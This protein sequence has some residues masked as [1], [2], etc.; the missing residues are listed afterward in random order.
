MYFAGPFKGAPLSLVAITPALAGPYDYGT[1][2]VRV[3]LH[4]DPL[5]AQVKAISDTV[6]AIIGGVPIRM[7]S[8]QVN[9]DRPNFTINPTSCAAMSVNSQG[10]GD[11]GTIADF[12][13]YFHA[14]NCRS[15]PF[16]PTMAIRQL[17]RRK[18]T[19]RTGNPRLQF[20]LRTRPGDANVKAITVTLSRAYA[21]D[22]THL[23]NICSEKELAA[24]ECAGRQPMG[25]AFTATPLLDQPISGLAYAVSGSGGLPR[26]AFILNGQVKLVPRADTKTVDGRLTTTVPVVPDAPIGHFRLKLFGGK[27]DYLV[28]TRDV[29]RRTPVIDVDFV[30]QN[31]KTRSQKIKV[32]APCGKGKARAKHR[33]R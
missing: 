14:V 19:H 10:I 12:S 31:D 6:P 5:T 30:G 16:K 32:K 9:I 27:Q 15:L 18:E 11:Q 20:D 23:G 33:H 2:V 29:C 7:R 28:N 3:A 8:I 4:V 1:Q 13:S 21:I 24:T 26:L 17:G 22:Q 25:E